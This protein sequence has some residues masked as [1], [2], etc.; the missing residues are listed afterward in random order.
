MR[1]KCTSQGTVSKRQPS[2]WPRASLKAGTRNLFEVSMSFPKRT[3]GWGAY[4]RW[5]ERHRIMREHGAF[6]EQKTRIE[7]IR[8]KQEE[9]N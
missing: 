6:W 3:V 8:G 1:N 9:R 5:R 4:S 7:G 2:D